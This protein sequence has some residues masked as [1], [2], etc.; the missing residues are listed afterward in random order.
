MLCPQP[1]WRVPCANNKALKRCTKFCL[2]HNLPRNCFKVCRHKK[3]SRG[4]RTH[5]RGH[6]QVLQVCPATAS[7]N[8][9]LF[10]LGS[11]SLLCRGVLRLWFWNSRFGKRHCRSVCSVALP[12]LIFMTFHVSFS[13]SFGQLMA[14]VVCLATGMW[15]RE[16][17][18][19]SAWFVV[20]HS[21]Y[22]TRQL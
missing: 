22:T 18:I 11:S 7:S 15:L 2:F 3:Y 1:P 19:C 12:G 4:T 21:S 20:S 17:L 8:S 5:S 9:P 14:L 16:A 6:L 10:S 13:P